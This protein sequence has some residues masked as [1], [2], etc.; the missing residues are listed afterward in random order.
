MLV[1]KIAVV[2][3]NFNG[4]NDTISCLR[5]LYCSK[6][7][8]AWTILVDNASSPAEQKILY[9]TIPQICE[10]DPAQCLLRA[11]SREQFSAS[12]Q[13]LPQTTRKNPFFFIQAAKNKGYSAGNNLGMLLALHL[14]ADAVWILNNDT[15]VAPE[16]LTHM[17]ERL[18]SSPRP[19]LCGSLIRYMA[20]PDF[21]QC[22]GGGHTNRWT[23]LSYLIGHKQSVSTMQMLPNEAVEKQ[24]NFIYGASVM[25]SKNFLTTVGVLDERY[26]MYCEEQDWAF[27]AAG[28][29]DLVYSRQAHVWHKEGA[30]TGWPKKANN[31]F[32]MRHLFR[33]RLLLAAKHTPVALPLVLTSVGYALL[34][35]IYRRL[36]RTNKCVV[37]SGK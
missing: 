8:P 3:L 35:M 34:R 28:R 36:F 13:S 23:G 26:F 29:F 24:L 15:V 2:V 27:R 21:V 37:S 19:G 12:L 17:R 14:G 9:R 10:F 30:S 11:S 32:A 20:E 33:S 4:M 18:F 16:T 22:L 31:F 25:V 6:E 1:Q 5:S 7:L